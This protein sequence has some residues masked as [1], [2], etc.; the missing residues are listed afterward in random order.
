MSM[1]ACV[2]ACVRARACARAYACVR[3]CVCV[4]VCVC[5]R[6]CVCVCMRVCVCVCMRVRVYACVY[7]CV[8]VCVR[9][10]VRVRACVRACV[11]VRACVCVCVCVCVLT[12]C[13]KPAHP[14]RG[15]WWLSCLGRKPIRQARGRSHVKTPSMYNNTRCTVTA[16][17]AI[18][19]HSQRWGPQWWPINWHQWDSFRSAVDDCSTLL[20][21]TPRTC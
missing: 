16:Y 1:R 19:C 17:T 20:C 9:V 4:C 8:C 12:T 6:V 5:M 14:R 13:C 21:Y 3:V 10:C 15:T 2:R 7:A 11:R 18:G